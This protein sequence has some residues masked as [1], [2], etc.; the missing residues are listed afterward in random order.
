MKQDQHAWY[1]HQ[2]TTYTYKNKTIIDIIYV[3]CI[4]TENGTLGPTDLPKVF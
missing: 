3:E 1:S 2:K 4:V